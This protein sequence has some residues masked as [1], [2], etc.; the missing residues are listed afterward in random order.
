MRLS[1]PVKADYGITVAQI[2]L[3]GTWYEQVL[4][5]TLPQLLHDE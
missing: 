5:A 3:F 1:L 2:V 4:A